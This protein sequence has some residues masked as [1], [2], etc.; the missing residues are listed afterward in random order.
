M[1]DLKIFQMDFLTTP[2]D[3]IKQEGREPLKNL[4][5]LRDAKIGT[6]K[7]KLINLYPNNYGNE[8]ALVVPAQDK[9]H[10]LTRLLK[11]PAMVT[12][13]PD[14]LTDTTRPVLLFTNEA[15]DPNRPPHILEVNYTAGE[16]LTITGNPSTAPA[17]V[18]EDPSREDTSIRPATPL[19]AGG[20]AAELVDVHTPQ[21][22]GLR[23]EQTM[24]L[25][26]PR[27]E[28]TPGSY[29]GTFGTRPTNPQRLGPFNQ[30]TPAFNQTAQLAQQPRLAKTEVKQDLS[31]H[32]NVAHPN[33]VPTPYQETV[34]PLHPGKLTITLPSFNPHSDSI[35]EVLAKL[36]KIIP[37]YGDP[38]AQRHAT[39]TII[40]NFLQ[41]SNL[42]HLILNLTADQLNNFGAF[43]QAMLRRYARVSPATDFYMITQ[44]IGEL[45]ADLMARLTRMWQRIK[46]TAQLDD[47]DRT[48]IRERFLSALRDPSIRLKLRES[49]AA[50]EDLPDIARRL[51]SAREVE[52][53]QPST[54]SLMYEIKTLRDEVEKLRFQPPCPKCGLGH[55]ESECRANSKQKAQHNKSVK[56]GRTPRRN[57]DYAIPIDGDGQAPNQR[58]GGH[59]QR[60]RGDRGRGHRGA[61]ARPYTRSPGFRD[62]TPEDNR[63]ARS[64]S[65]DRDYIRNRTPSPYRRNYLVEHDFF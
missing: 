57:N 4:W 15:H 8:I 27:G 45:E 64:R 34:R 24:E 43:K 5:R 39:P 55:K 33:L 31:T 49:N 50:F 65:Y 40:L 21:R 47:G 42:D 19:Q 48:V 59:A 11:D 41:A 17:D 44:S 25:S 28:S 46:N 29:S 1:S 14:A 37:L 53:S 20:P 56:F 18:T 3:N 13:V 62:R 23:P 10:I 6:F 36:Q 30:P 22:Q 52:D 32:V 7:N 58:R 61:R 63:R 2:H 60:G 16:V 54:I 51:R 38:Q 9:G 26:A 35:E 12:S